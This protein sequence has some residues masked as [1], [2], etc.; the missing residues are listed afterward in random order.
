[1]TPERLQVLIE[2]HDR[3]RS[4]EFTLGQ[5]RTHRG[6]DH[7]VSESAAQRARKIIEQDLE[8][9]LAEAKREFEAA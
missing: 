3:V 5:H 6:V 8:E 7:L 1:M 4:L 9:Q 2:L